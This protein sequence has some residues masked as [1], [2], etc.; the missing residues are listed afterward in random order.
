MKNDTE[1]RGWP[2]REVTYGAEFAAFDALPPPLRR[3]LAG[4]KVKWTAT[5]IADALAGGMSV[6]EILVEFDAADA[7]ALAADRQGMAA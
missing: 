2:S 3:A 1:M 6:N 7:A 5:A 4:A